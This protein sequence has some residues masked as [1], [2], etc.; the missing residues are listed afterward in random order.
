[1]PDSLIPDQ[2]GI[3]VGDGPPASGAGLSNS[4]SAAAWDQAAKAFGSFEGLVQEHQ[5]LADRAHVARIN[6]S[7]ETTQQ[8]LAQT[9][10]YDAG[11]LRS[12]LSDAR[13]Q[14]VQSVGSRY[15]MQAAQQWDLKADETLRSTSA[16]QFALD[17]KQNG[18]SLGQRNELLNRQ[19]AAEYGSGAPLSISNASPT[20]QANLQEMASNRAALVASRHWTPEQAQIDA[21]ASK[22]DFMAGAFSSHVLDLAQKGGTPQAG[23]EA[24]RLEIERLRTG[25]LLGAPK[26]DGAAWE[27]ETELS[28]QMRQ[29]MVSKAYST[30]RQASTDMLSAQRLQEQQQA[31]VKTAFQQRMTAAINTAFATGKVDDTF[32]PSDFSKL[33]LRFDEF[34]KQV[35]AA[36]DDHEAVGDAARFPT[37]QA[38]LD[39]RL[40][41]SAAAAANPGEAKT[42]IDLHA[43]FLTVLGGEGGVKNGVPQRSP[44]GA[45]GA[46][47]VTLD[48]ARTILQR[49]PD[50]LPGG[51]SVSDERLTALLMDPDQRL[52]LRFGETHWGDL[53]SDFGDQRLAALAYHGGPGAVR[54]MTTAAGGNPALAG[55]PSWDAAL[56]AWEARGNPKDAAYVRSFT[57]RYAVGHQQATVAHVQSEDDPWGRGRPALARDPLTFAQGHNM[58]TVT[59]LPDF[60]DPSW[61]KALQQRFVTGQQLAGQYQVTPRMLTDVESKTF[62]DALHRD[63]TIAVPLARQARAALG[64]DGANALLSE[65]G[66]RG[67]AASMGLQ[68]ARLSTLGRDAFVNAASA[69]MVNATDKFDVEPHLKTRDGWAAV[70]APF[71]PAFR[72]LPPDRMGAITGLAKAARLGDAHGGSLDTPESYFDAAAGGVHNHQGVRFGGVDRDVNGAPVLLP[73]WMKQGTMPRALMAVGDDLAAKGAGPRYANGQPMRGADLSRMQPVVQPDNSYALINPRT[74]GYV[75]DGHGGR[76]KVD[77]EGFRARLAPLGVVGVQSARVAAR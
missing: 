25:A 45:M 1:M 55:G 8:G 66:V 44:Q 43:G 4:A 65:V 29:A 31:Q 53:V 6:S 71:S 2:P 30:L 49:H 60:R 64:D 69:G 41:V 32:Q 19:T 11:S 20:I 5:D 14:F 59:P 67:G 40:Q 27:G 22:T 10:P 54:G 38:Y 47:Q 63:P 77:L 3:T 61:A 52:N 70:T 9:N 51:Q 33:G 7:I 56:S 74:G 23:L 13:S 76:F 37:Y 12:S 15:A 72:D 42:P 58:A 68:L 50:L 75:D 16:Q 18:D 73:S 26:P 21:D 39:H 17:W 48:T 57:A 62:A 46:S 28:A 36:A 24:A 35:Q 34:T